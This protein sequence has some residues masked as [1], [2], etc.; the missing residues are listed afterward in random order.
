VTRRQWPAIGGGLLVAGWGLG[1]PWLLNLGLAVLCAGALAWL[2]ARGALARVHYERELASTAVFAGEATEVE[3]S[4]ANDK[5]LPLAWLRVRDHVPEGLA[6]GGARLEAS[7]RARRRVLVHLAALRP[8]ERI[9]W[10]HRVSCPK[11]GHYRFGPV[12]LAAGDVFG[13]YD[14]RR[15]DPAPLTL[16]V[17][18]LVRP[19][20]AL[21][22]PPGEPFGGRGT[23]RPLLRD[24]LRPVGLREARPEDPRRR[25]NWKATARDPGGALRVNVLEPVSQ[26]ALM[27]V[28][29]MAT[30]AEAWRGVDPERQEA[31]IAVAASIA[32]DAARRGHAVGIAAN[33]GMPDSGRP[34]HVPPGRSPAA[35]KHVLTALAAVSPFIRGPVERL[36]ASEGRRAPWG[37]TIVLVTAHMTDAV[38]GELLRLR[39]A[40]RRVALVSLDPADRRAIPGVAIHRIGP[41]GMRAAMTASPGGD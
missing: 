2:W 14:A 31:A 16:V 28:L 34:I 7:S 21:G 8:Y 22:F 10:R 29:D 13:F 19:L 12:E 17:Y 1:S 25:V 23:D 40:G 15:E 27:I 38:A 26:M 36:L 39:R 32:A 30:A 3:V 37:A 11:R 33:G 41:D 35:L 6:Y 5:L 24:P 4:L 20:A 9:A 18:P